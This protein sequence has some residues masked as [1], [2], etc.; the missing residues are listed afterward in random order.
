MHPHIH[1][2]VLMTQKIQ[3]TIKRPCLK[4]KSL[5]RRGCSQ[6]RASMCLGPSP[7]WVSRKI[8][9]KQHVMEKSISFH[10]KQSH[11]RSLSLPPQE[12]LKM[13]SRNSRKWSRSL[14]LSV[15]TLSD[16]LI[17]A[18]LFPRKNFGSEIAAGWGFGTSCD[19]SERPGGVLSTSSGLV[20]E[21]EEQGF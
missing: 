7:T 8:N 21:Y 10:V 20:L 16:C 17:A 11:P 18:C 4:I 15:L 12:F 5:K 6:V 13:F 9:K 14:L 19:H 2:R 3:I 1:K